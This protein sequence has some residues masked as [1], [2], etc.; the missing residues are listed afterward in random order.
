MPKL[1]K[2]VVAVNQVVSGQSLKTLAY[3]YQ[4]AYSN[5]LSTAKRLMGDGITGLDGVTG[6][7]T[8]STLRTF[9]FRSID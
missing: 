1:K 9:Y 6:G 7:W 8:I 5:M 3:E 4:G 2:S